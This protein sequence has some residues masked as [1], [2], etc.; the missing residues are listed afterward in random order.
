MSRWLPTLNLLGVVALAVI[1]ALQWQR[2]RA[3]NLELNGS[4]KARWQQQTKIAEQEK[5]LG[6]L[7]DDLA[8]L[9]ERLSGTKAENDEARQKLRQLEQ[10]NQSLVVARDRLQ[11]S[12]ARWTNA[13]AVRDQRLAEA[14]ESIRVANERTRTLGEQLNASILKF[15]EL[16][17]NYNAVV[18]ELNVARR[19]P[20]AGATNTAAR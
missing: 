10:E 19:A 20:G 7:T 5:Q 18:E 1:C 14:N 3:L 4:E 2:D 17:T 9:K 12:L 11:E 16:A 8:L 13:V 15:N 6:G